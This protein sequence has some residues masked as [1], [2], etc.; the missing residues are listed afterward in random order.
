MQAVE[1]LR[2]FYQ[3]VRKRT[4]SRDA[5]C[6]VQIP[7]SKEIEARFCCGAPPG[8][9]ERAV[10]FV[11]SRTRDLDLWRVFDSRSMDFVAG[12]RWPPLRFSFTSLSYFVTKSF[13]KTMQRVYVFR[14]GCEG[15]RS[16]INTN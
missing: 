1:C 2:T 14:S 13:Y 8:F 4:A 12:P 9:P 7:V 16:Y 3:R 15:S 6:C 10:A 11:A 5:I